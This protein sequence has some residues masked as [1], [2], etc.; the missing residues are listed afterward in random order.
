MRKQM[1]AD[2]MEG[3]LTTPPLWLCPSVSLHPTQ[4]PKVFT[5]SVLCPECPLSVVLFNSYSSF[6]SQLQAPLLWETMAPLPLSSDRPLF[7]LDAAYPGLTP[8]NLAQ[9]LKLF[10]LPGLSSRPGSDPLLGLR[11]L[12]VSPC[13]RC[14][15]S[16]AQ[17]GSTA[18]MCSAR[19][20]R[21]QT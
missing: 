21:C 15:I 8:Q 20:R 10:D 4:F 19:L 9:R 6:K 2:R 11:G 5:R 7:P 17:A 13:S 12:L 14:R 18:L 16:Q 1:T 3:W